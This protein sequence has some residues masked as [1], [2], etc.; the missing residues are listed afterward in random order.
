VG[1][2][3]NQPTTRARRSVHPASD[4]IRSP[5]NYRFEP[6]NLAVKLVRRKASICAPIRPRE[7]EYVGERGVRMRSD[8]QRWIRAWP[9]F[10]FTSNGD[11][12]SFP[13][14]PSDTHRIL[15]Y[16]NACAGHPSFSRYPSDEPLMLL[17][18]RPQGQQS[19]AR[20]S[21]FPLNN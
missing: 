16:L 21:P 13:L 14:A 11:D 19:P 9:P 1:R 6:A 4:S 7:V 17:G 10:P 3:A 12:P 8:L 15:S 2:K 5:A 20:P 18:V